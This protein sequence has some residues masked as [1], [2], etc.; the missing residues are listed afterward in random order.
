MS[1]F[2]SDPVQALEKTEAKIASVKSNIDALRVQRAQR[3]LEA[4]E[5][6]SEVT[7]IDVAIEAE[8]R[9]V[10]I[11]GDRC[12]EEMR[13]REY[14]ERE[15][16][17]QESRRQDFRPTKEAGGDGRKAT[18]GAYCHRPAVFRAHGP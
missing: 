6:G 13:R 10:V 11:L 3:L 15:D 1:L 5:P 4:E 14:Q 9:N 8:G 17:T 18:G 12:R 2:K 16:P 7:K